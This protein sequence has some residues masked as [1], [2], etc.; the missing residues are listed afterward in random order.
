[1]FQNDKTLLLIS[2]TL[3]VIPHATYPVLQHQ[4][5]HPFACHFLPYAP[6][7]ADAPDIALPLRVKLQSAKPYASPEAC[8]AV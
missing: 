7:I 8:S 3:F 5:P 2:T 1:M 4:L 6:E